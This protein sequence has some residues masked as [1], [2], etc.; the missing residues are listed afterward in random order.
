MLATLVD[1]DPRLAYQE[2][3]KLLAY[4]NY[5]RTVEADDVQMLTADVGQG[6]VF[7]LVEALGNRDGRKALGMLQRLLE[8]QDYFSIFGMVVRQFRQLILTRDIL[9]SGGGK[10]EIVRGLKLFPNPW[11]AERL[12]IQARRF[13]AHDLVRIY[14]RLLEVDEAVKTSQ[15]TGD[16]ALVTLVASLT[17]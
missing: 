4:V 14:H 1:S 17:V 6:D 9:D 5:S 13:T 15:M 2:T 3:Q 12:I 8:Y 10:D 7:V 11:L 16:L